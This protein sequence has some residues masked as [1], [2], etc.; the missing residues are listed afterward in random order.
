LDNTSHLAE[1]T[2]KEEFQTRWRLTK[3]SWQEMEDE[4]VKNFL[5]Y[6][7]NQ[8]INKNQNWY[9]RIC[10]IGIGNTNNALEGFNCAFKRHYTSYERQD[11]VRFGQCILLIF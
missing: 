6:F 11:I 3:E 9:L 4:T 1:R 2:S 7:E 8:Y 5:T 10:P